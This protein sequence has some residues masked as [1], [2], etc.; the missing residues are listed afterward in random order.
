MEVVKVDT[1]AETTIRP[2]VKAAGGK[3]KL[4]PEIMKLMPVFT[5]RYHEP[6][7]GGGAVFLAVSVVAGARGLSGRGTLNDNN[8]ELM[9]AYAV[10]QKHPA[11]LIKKLQSI[12]HSS[13]TYYRIRGEESTLSLDRAVRTLYLNR[14]CFNGL[15][16]VNR[17]GK[18][19]VPIGSY[20]NPTIV[21][22]ENILKLSRALQGVELFSE[23]FA[24]RI[25][26]AKKHDWIYCDPP[27]L[28]RSKT[29]NFT[30]YTAEK[31][32]LKDHERL[33][34]SLMKA[35]RRGVSWMLSEG[36]SEAIRS[37]FKAFQIHAVSC[38]HMVGAK[39]SSRTVVGELLVTN[40]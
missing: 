35:S 24:T 34:E 12:K 7:V 31:F 37:L 11:A 28:P 2:I 9:N 25:D 1:N 29:A 4:V 10:V 33:A 13:E 22:P 14:T 30:S 15:Y 8:A 36:D 18:F 27:Y 32:D 20:V 23:D 17:S 21:D 39:A 6:F 19:N 3:T 40:Y 5:G 26:T 16:R 38:K